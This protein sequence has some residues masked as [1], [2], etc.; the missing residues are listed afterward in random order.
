VDGQLVTLHPGQLATLFPR[1]RP[2]V[3]QVDTSIY[4]AWTEGRLVFTKTPLREAARELAR[5]YDLDVRL[6]DKSLAN[7]HVTA[8]FKDESPAEVLE[9]LANALDVRYERDGRTVTFY[10]RIDRR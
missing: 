3:S 6:A 9:Y 8:S 10:R 2:T 4:L 5:W 1:A 7:R